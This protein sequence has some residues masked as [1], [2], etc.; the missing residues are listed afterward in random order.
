[1]PRR[2][3]RSAGRWGGARG[4]VDVAGAGRT[5]VSALAC[6]KEPSATRKGAPPGI[7]SHCRFRNRSTE[8]VS[9]SGMKW[10]SGGTKRQCGR[11]LAPALD[12]CG[13]REHGVVVDLPGRSR[14]GATLSLGAHL[15]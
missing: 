7:R 15:R 6:W 1:M 2:T 11:A 12:D 8:Y 4:V 9:E 10:M 3:Q 5:R 13:E 14:P